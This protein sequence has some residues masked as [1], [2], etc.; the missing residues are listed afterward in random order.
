[1]HG[2]VPFKDKQDEVLWSLVILSLKPYLVMTYFWFI[3]RSTLS[4]FGND[5]S[6][7]L[8]HKFQSNENYFETV[9]MNTG[10][11]Q[12]MLHVYRWTKYYMSYI[13]KIDTD[14]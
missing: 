10:T 13:S 9:Q 5:K 6:E 2:E 14:T 12:D 8:Y 4:L 1:M 3:S 11:P 7:F